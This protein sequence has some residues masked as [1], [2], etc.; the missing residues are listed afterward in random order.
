LSYYQSVQYA[1]RTVACGITSVRDAGG[2][3]LGMKTAIER[4]IIAGPRM[5]VAINLMSQTGGHGDGHRHSGI[6]IPLLPVTPGR[7]SGIADGPDECRKV[8]RRL[9]R[10]GADHIKICTSGGVLSPSDDPRHPQF[11]VDEIR[12][13]V[14]EAEAHGT[15]VMAHAQGTGGI[16]NA[17]LGGVRTIE[18]GIYLDAETIDLMLEKDAWLVPT[19]V[20]PQMVLSSADKPN[21]GLPP[22]VVAKARMV[23][24]VHREAV[25]RAYEA[26][27]N[28]GM[29]TDTGVGPHGSNLEELWLMHQ[30]GMSLEEVLRAATG[31]AAQF[32]GGIGGVVAVG[33]VA[34]LVVLTST[35]SSAAQL[36]DL[37]SL[38]GDVYVDGRPVVRASSTVAE[39]RLGTEVDES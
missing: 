12:A 35:L 31:D 29:G 33:G 25:R 8:A 30:I 2:A 24:D 6:D 36:H 22:A 11:T 17:L 28:I 32:V 38:I 7:P 20:A 27:V 4:G 3:D 34:D 14:D 16:R 15:H 9:F 19:L 37:S 23:A 26:G 10:A 13:I 21:S 18:H 39:G 5:R 1:E